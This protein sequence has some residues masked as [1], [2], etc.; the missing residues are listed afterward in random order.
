[1][2]SVNTDI[3]VNDSS[4]AGELQTLR[5]QL[6]ALTRRVYRLEQ[7]LAGD[8]I[9]S[10]G[11]EQQGAA[12]PHP[13]RQFEPALPHDERLYEPAPPPVVTDPT[14]TFPAAP[15]FHAQAPPPAALHTSLEAR[16]GG[17]WLNRL[18]II[19]VLVGLSYFL[20]LAF[21]NNW[22][23]PGTQVSIGMVAG[24]AV[25]FW[26]ESF[27]RKGYPAFAY[28]LKAV[29]FGA[30]YLSLWA[31]SQY[32]HLVP[33]AVTFFG[34]I[35]VTLTATAL[36]LRQNAELLAAFALVGGFLT[37]VLVSTGENHEVALFCYLALLD[38][39]SVWIVAL[40]RWPRLLL[41][42]FAGT[43]ALFAAWA[44]TYYSAPQ[45]ATTLLFASGFFLLYAM[46][47]FL[48][49]SS[50]G[51]SELMVGLTLANAAAY[52]AASYLMLA[53][54]YRLELA[55]LTAG[56]AAFYFAMGRL[57]QKREAPASPLYGP[58]TLALAVGFLTVAMPLKLDAYW[59]TLGW[60]VEAGALFWAAHRSSNLLLRAL[61]AVA[62]LLGVLR[63]LVV[64]SEAYET[65]LLNP[66]FGLYLLAIAALVLLAHY[67]IV[68]G[69]E[70][71]RQWAAGAILALNV[72]ALAALNFEVR[73]YFRPAPGQPFSAVQWRGIETARAFTY[74]A[75][76]MVYGG[77]LMLVG[78]WKRS[79][80]L[81]WQAIV[82]LALTAAKVFFYDIGELQR[83]YRIAAF[84]VLGAIL[85]VVSF[86][87]QRTRLKATQ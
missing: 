53:N 63:L 83:G 49:S 27:R 41:G 30:L 7:L 12:E 55:W 47:P 75:V 45:L 65:L 37:P 3:S 61:G 46:A 77:A 8:V 19:A 5:E 79:A 74:S 40:K 6:A 17:Q 51:Y 82:L 39:G 64:D 48:S 11:L 22:I 68:E 57:L 73:D 18:G 84:I 14:A 76:W 31:A 35:M 9:Q 29:A 23:G 80:F 44:T 72:L 38:L 13:E 87:Y 71:N 28:S 24:L 15:T 52:F 50:A 33:P 78:F 67:A 25:L 21:E 81:R 10:A 26:S 43:V 34:M 1:M 16:I 20:K 59:L 60:L 42:S 62:L 85:L 2:V 32:Y 66:R 86:F 56:L 36:S 54:H 69:G 4:Q 70:T 58:A